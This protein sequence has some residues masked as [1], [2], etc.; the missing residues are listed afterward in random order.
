MYEGTLRDNL[1]PEKVKSSEAINE[2]LQKSHVLLKRAKKEQKTENETKE[3]KQN[4][5]DENFLIEKNGRN[6]SNGEKQIINFLR[7]MLMDRNIVFLDEAT[8]N[9]DPATGKKFCKYRP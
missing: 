1:D 5:L 4:I 2:I 3:N 6:L 8:S 7:A 9:L